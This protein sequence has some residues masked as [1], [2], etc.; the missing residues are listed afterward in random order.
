MLNNVSVGSI[1][2][3]MLSLTVVLL[4]NH[5]QSFLLSYKDG[6]TFLKEI[7]AVTIII[8]KKKISFSSMF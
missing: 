5:R 6:T 2:G 3:D 4:P 8:H 1:S 7:K